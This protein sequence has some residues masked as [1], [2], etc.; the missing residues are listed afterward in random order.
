MFTNAK[1]KVQHAK[2]QAAQAAVSL[3]TTAAPHLQQMLTPQT[4]QMNSSPMM[5]QQQQ[6]QSKEAVAVMAASAA[7]ATAATA[8]AGA[9]A[10]GAHAAA[11]AAPA[12][13]GSQNA[14]VTVELTRLAAGA[15]GAGALAVAGAAT[16]LG[17]TAANEMAREVTLPPPPPPTCWC[18]FK[19]LDPGC[20]ATT[21]KV[22]L[23]LPAIV[24]SIIGF[25]PYVASESCVF[26]L[27]ILLCVCDSKERKRIMEVLA[28]RSSTSRGKHGEW[29]ILR[30]ARAAADISCLGCC[31]VCCQQCIMLNGK[32]DPDCGCCEE[33]LKSSQIYGHCLEAP[34]QVCL[35][36]NKE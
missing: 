23:M 7:V 26:Y 1:E 5:Q 2:A 36:D 12:A 31:H 16:T 24:A 6:P 18:G 9:A 30:E 11:S 29:E 25:F 34:C 20:C 10:V 15:V 21:A 14:A 19:P 8:M 33:R 32:L 22:A 27:G 3:A 17:G 35:L 13:S 4:Q 28:R